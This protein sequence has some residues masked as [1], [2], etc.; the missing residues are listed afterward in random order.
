MLMDV[1][2]AGGRLVAVGE[3]GHIIISDDHGKSW[4]QAEVPTSVT[5]TAV[6]FS[7]PKIGWVVGHDSVILY[8]CDAGE[9]WVKQF[10]GNEVN[11]KVLNAVEELLACK[12]AELALASEAERAEREL[13]LEDVQFFLKDARMA[14]HEGPTRPFMDVWFKNEHE[15]LIVGSFGMIFRTDDGGET[16]TSLIERIE[17]VQGFHYYGLTSTKGVLLLAGEAGILYSSIDDGRS[18]NRLESKYG[19]SLFGIVGEPSW[20]CAVAVGLGGNLVSTGDNGHTWQHK[21]P[22]SGTALNGGTV[23]SDGTLVI[24][25][26]AGVAL[27]SRDGGITFTLL[28]TNFGRC[29][30]VADSGDGHLVLVGPQGVRRVRIDVLTQKASEE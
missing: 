15:G 9:T 21:K 29:M 26:Q 17:N 6:F 7:T 25:G 24:V 5:L 23:L 2:K 12:E 4:T 13:E 16:W 8:S 3:R 27:L 14:V 11:E 22:L 20:S 18:W 1:T 19:G 30:A 28:N 10:G